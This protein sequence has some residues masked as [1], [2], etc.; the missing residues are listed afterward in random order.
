M[1]I[2][3]I[4]DPS[5][6]SFAECL[7][8]LNR[9]DRECLHAVRNS[10]VYKLFAP[11]GSPVLVRIREEA[12]KP[13]LVADILHGRL[14]AEGEKNIRNFITRWLHLDG[15]MGPFYDFSAK[16]ALL[17]PLV[18][19][20]NGL[21]LIGIPDLFEAVTWTITGQQINLGF[22]YTLK[23]RLIQAFGYVLEEGGHT[24]H[25][26]PHP[27]VIAVLQPE[28]LTV[29]QFSRSKAEALIRVAKLMAAGELNEEKIAAQS[30]EEAKNTLTAIKGIGPWS[31]NYVLMKFAQHPQALPLEDA[32]LHN[33][34]KARLNMP[35]KPTL[36]EVKQITRH[37]QQHAAYATFYCW[38]ALSN[39]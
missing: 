28:A 38:R 7:L 5:H 15:D 24:Y 22:A 21:R 37:W 6:F 11:E 14:S 39:G 32:G 3:P 13:F 4:T 17:G 19:D 35:A 25:L 1:I 26:Y 8:F 18:R 36:A 23:Q 33:A 31:A 34:L 10:A 16:D 2:L 9:S 20:Y 12:G 27:A 30:F 29:M